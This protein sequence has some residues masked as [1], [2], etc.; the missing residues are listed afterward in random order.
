[1]SNPDLGDQISHILASLEKATP[2]ML[3]LATRTMRFDALVNG[4]LY[5]LLILL[6]LSTA[7]WLRCWILRDIAQEP[8]EQA[9]ETLRIFA[10]LGVVACCGLIIIPLCQL[11]EQ[12]SKLVNAKYYAVA[13]L[14]ARVR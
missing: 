11:P 9:D 13:D 6:L 8:R 12:A 1:M 14:L 4:G 7:W 5:L 2:E 3:T 10:I